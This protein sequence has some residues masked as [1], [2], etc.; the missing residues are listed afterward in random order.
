MCF[1]RRKL[2]VWFDVLR[3]RLKGTRD[4]TRRLNSFC[5]FEKRIESVLV[6]LCKDV[7]RL[8]PLTPS[9]FIFFISSI[10]SFFLLFFFMMNFFIRF[11]LYSYLSRFRSFSIIISSSIRSTYFF[12]P[13]DSSGLHISLI[14]E[15]PHLFTFS[16]PSFSFFFLPFHFYSDYLPLLHFLSSSFLRL[17][18][19]E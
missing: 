4:L 11:F 9:Y 13:L 14:S 19:L 7:T 3:F 16:F 10:S 17:F 12:L 2:V 6:G 8:A 5:V 15:L 18:P 1:G